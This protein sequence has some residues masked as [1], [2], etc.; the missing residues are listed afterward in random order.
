MIPNMY[1]IAGQLLPAVIHVA[2]RSLGTHGLNLQPD[3]QDIMAV[4]QT[5]WTILFS[6]TPQMCH[7]M[8]ILAHIGTMETSVPVIHA[9]DGFRTSHEINKVELSSYEE[10]KGLLPT[11]AIRQFRETALTPLQPTMRGMALGQEIF[12]AAHE[13]GNPVRDRVVPTLAR[14]AE[15]ISAVTGRSFAFYAYEGAPDAEH[16][17]VLMGSACLTVESVVKSL[18]CLICLKLRAGGRSGC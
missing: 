3:H 14:C 11:D 13:A 9:F 8:A 2:C 15:R 17:V 5:G 6:E 16:I 7:D 4:R 1:K 18:T 10:L 12:F